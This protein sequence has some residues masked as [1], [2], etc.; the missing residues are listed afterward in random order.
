M[1]CQQI[2]CEQIECQQIECDVQLKRE[3]QLASALEGSNITVLANES[4]GDF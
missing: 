3:S 1:C 2:E 4:V